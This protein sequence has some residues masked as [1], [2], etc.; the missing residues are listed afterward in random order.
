[1]DVVLSGERQKKEMIHFIMGHVALLIKRDEGPP[2][3]HELPARAT[4]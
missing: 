1:M 4:S 2:G 3:L